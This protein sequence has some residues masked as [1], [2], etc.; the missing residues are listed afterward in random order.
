MVDSMR[1]PLT[2]TAGGVTYAGLSPAV[3]LARGVADS[4]VL[5]NFVAALERLVDETAETL[6]LKLMTAGTGQVMEY[7]EAQAEAAAALSAPGNAT[8]VL[9][10]MLAAS[11][12]I[13]IDPSTKAVATDV[14]G[15]A[16]AV[17]ATHDAWVAAGAAIRKARLAGKAAIDAA[18]TVA[19]AAAAYAAIVWPVV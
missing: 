10:P 9:Y 19:A 4:V 13:D 12:G 5:P 16:R 14:L 1:T 15:V 2:F 18:T 3:L 17:N 7:Q 11:I 8:A 6:R